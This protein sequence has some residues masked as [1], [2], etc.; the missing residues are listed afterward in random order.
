MATNKGS[1]SAT[2][3]KHISSRRILRFPQLK[4]KIIADVELG[5]SADDFSLTFFFQDKTAL[6]F[7]IEPGIRLVPELADC[8]GDWKL[9]KRWRP[10]QS[11]SSIL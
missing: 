10:V 8:K 6:S 11:K 1:R 2:P 3:H 9:L 4:G 5:A 7:D